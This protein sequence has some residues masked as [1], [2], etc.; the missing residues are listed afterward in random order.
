[1]SRKTTTAHPCYIIRPI[2]C[3]KL[4]PWIWMATVARSHET[5]A[6]HVIMESAR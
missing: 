5:D 4:L 1:M 3:M 6:I 2:S